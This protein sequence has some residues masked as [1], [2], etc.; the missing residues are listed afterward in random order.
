MTLYLLDTNTVSYLA[1]RA[2]AFHEPAKHRLG[3]IPE[4]SEVAISILTLYELTYGFVHD[5]ARSRLLSIVR[6]GQV[7]IVPLTEA[8]S[9]VFAALKH[10]YRR[11]TGGRA[12]ALSRHNV[13]LILA[14]S[15]IVEGA[16]LVSNDALFR[17]LA[18]LEPRLTV[19]N[20]AA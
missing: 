4:E 19:E 20:W 6:E 7:R 8:G 1:D 14:S 5:P 13:D 17:T 18:E 16:V 3:S 10:A 2:S 12:K 11:R 9:E 15:A